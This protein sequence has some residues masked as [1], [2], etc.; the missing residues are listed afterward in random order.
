MGKVVCRKDTDNGLAASTVRQRIDY[1]VAAVVARVIFML[2]SPASAAPG[3]LRNA[4]GHAY[5][6]KSDWC[7]RIANAIE[8][9]ADQ[10]A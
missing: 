10:H 3:L 5:R 9:W 7:K 6:S 2:I 8:S 1:C 4:G